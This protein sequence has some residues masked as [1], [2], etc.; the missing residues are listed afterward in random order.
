VMVYLDRN[1]RRVAE[2]AAQA[3]LDHHMPESTYLA[4][5]GCRHLD[6]QAGLTPQQHF[7]ESAKVGLAE[8]FDFGEPGQ[9]HVRLN[10]ATSEEIL[11]EIL[12]RLGDALSPR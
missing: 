4:W 10:F 1:R 12:G 5:M 7:L 11:E 9:G 2:W 8:G 6:V 3:N